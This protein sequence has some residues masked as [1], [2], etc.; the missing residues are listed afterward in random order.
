MNA[1][2]Q[3][4]QEVISGNYNAFEELVEKYQGRIFRHLRKMVKDDPAA[5]DLLQE[6][7][8]S[9]YRGLDRFTGASSFSTWLFR[10]AT[11]AALMYLR[12]NRPEVME[13]DDEFRNQAENSLFPSSMEFS[14]T[15]L[16]I[17]LSQEGQ[18]KIEEVI[19]SL[20]LLYRSVIVLRDIEGFSLEEVSKIMDSSVAA[21]KSRLHRARNSVRE[22][23][24]SYYVDKSFSSGRQRVS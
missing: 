7:F 8:L 6:T 1:D 4:V 19:E 10:I 16:E 14:G 5:Q 22:A 11:N 15:P 20:P 3:I 12:K 18:R 13:Y 24:S 2:R 9:A 21:I 17:L 23:L